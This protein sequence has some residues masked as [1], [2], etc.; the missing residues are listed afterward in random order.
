MLRFFLLDDDELSNEL[1]TYIFESAGVTRYDIRTSGEEALQFLENCRQFNQFPDIMFVDINMPGMNGFE[2]I[3]EYEN[4]Y[5]LHSMSTRVILLTNSVLSSEKKL[6]KEYESI[7]DFWN[8]PLTP[9]MLTGLIR[10]INGA[11]N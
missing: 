2:F 7:F 4:R 1:V 3:T 5:R 8:K 6:A 10:K 9:E 11:T